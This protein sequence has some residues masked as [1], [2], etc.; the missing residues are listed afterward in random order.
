MA[1][2]S[3]LP[4]SHRF[5]VA[6]SSLTLVVAGAACSSD[7][8]RSTA[9]FCE[10]LRAEAPMLEGPLTTP[11]D[12]SAMVA[13]YRSLADVAPLSIEAEWQQVTELVEAAAA[14]DTDDP[15]A[16]RALNDRAYATEQAARTVSAWA[17]ERCQ[18]DLPVG[19]LA[20]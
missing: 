16:M 19:G 11:D 5:A 8:G 7:P 12:V 15:E 4:R 6:I 18:M 1:L 14:V 20:P 9:A 2:A 3:I 13:R 10:R 17:S